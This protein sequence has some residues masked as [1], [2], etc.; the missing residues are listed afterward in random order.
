MSLSQAGNVLGVCHLNHY[1]QGWILLLFTG[2][3]PASVM[4]GNLVAGKRIAQAAGRD[5]GQIEENDLVRKVSFRHVKFLPVSSGQSAMWFSYGGLWN[6]L[7]S[8]PFF[9]FVTLAPVPGWDFAVASPG[10]SWPRTLHALK[11][12]G[13]TSHLQD[14]RVFAWHGPG[15]GF[16]PQYYVTG[17]GDACLESQHW[18]VKTERC[19]VKDHPQSTYLGHL[20]HCLKTSTWV[21]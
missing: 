20:R 13:I 11:C 8:S 21:E 17:H 1:L 2:V 5:L 15:S 10:N 12:Q 16:N 3:G 6:L 14:W 18:A 19:G 7:T 4:V 9:C